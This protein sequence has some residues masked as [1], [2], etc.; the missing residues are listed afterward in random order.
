MK[1]ANIV[2]SLI[3]II[4]SLVVI[5]Y[6]Y[7][8]FPAGMGGVPG[9]AVFPIIIMV[10]M[11][12]SGI[13]VLVDTIRTNSQEPLELLGKDNIR[14]Y[15]TMAILIVYMLLIPVLGFIVTSTIFLTATIRWFSE[16]K[17]VVSFLW[18]IAMSGVV[19]AV[20]TYL[21]KVSLRF[22]LLI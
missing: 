17:I 20:F 1:K 8:K 13:V 22:G 18:A 10:M 15:I 14:V 16:K 2:T 4:F 12:L 19:F 9:P 21:L 3:C 5:V 11:L 6:T 7:T